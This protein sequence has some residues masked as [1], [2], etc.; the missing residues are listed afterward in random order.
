MVKRVGRRFFCSGDNAYP[1]NNSMMIPY[2]GVQR[3]EDYR[4]VYNFYLSQLRIR[5]ECCFGR[6]SSKWRIFRRNLVYS[7][8]KNSLIARIGAKLHN[9]VINAD[10]LN[11]KQFDNDDLYNL[12]VDVLMNGPPGNRGYLSVRSVGRTTNILLPHDGDRRE[13][14]YIR[15]KEMDLQR[16]EHNVDHNG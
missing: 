15:M 14:I 11:L 9:Y 2:S 12:E 6:L 3:F 5:I 7:T 16:L 8:A 13:A 4:L 1:M 10:D